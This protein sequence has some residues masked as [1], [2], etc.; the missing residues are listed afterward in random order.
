MYSV[1]VAPEILPSSRCVKILSLIRCSCDSQG[2][3]R[4]SLLWELAGEPVNHSAAIPIREVPLGSVSMR[5]LI[6]LYH[7]DD[8]M[9]SVVC[10]SINSL[11]SDSFA[12]NVSSSETQLGRGICRMLH[13]YLAF[14]LHNLPL[15]GF[16]D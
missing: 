5:S 7:L 11:G 2:N 6:T 9:P 12:F 8:D 1:S 13:F 10:L 3:P 15:S 14:L 16:T 4:P